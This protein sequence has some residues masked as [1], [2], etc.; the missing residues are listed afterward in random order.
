MPKVSKFFRVAVEGATV[1]GRAIDRQQ[2]IEMAASYNRDT[3]AARVNMEH[4][5]GITADKPFRAL[6]DVIALKT[7]EVEIELDGKKVKKLALFAQITPND[8]LLAIL[9]ADQKRYTSIEINPNFA[10]TGK[11]YLMG[12][13]VTDSPASLGTEFIQFVA[14]QREKG[15]DPLANRRLSASNLFTAGVETAM[16][17]DDVAVDP[18]KT[19]A[20]GFFAAGAEFFKSLI[21]NKS[22]PQTPPPPVVPPVDP[23]KPANDNDARFAAVASGMEQMTKGIEALTAGLNTRLASLQAEIGTVRASIETTVKPNQFNRQPAPGGEDRP[24]ADC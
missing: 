18:A 4:I 16:E 15:V 13:A 20:A 22:D 12:L 19:D 2:L 6:G 3:Y 8:D 24:R 17:F 9:A 5:R 14:G 1:D 11:A 21:G 23:D 10:A 7:E